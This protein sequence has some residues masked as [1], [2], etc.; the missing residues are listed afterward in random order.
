MQ[1]AFDGLIYSIYSPSDFPDD[2]GK[3]FALRLPAGKHRF[4]SWVVRG[5]F[6]T[7]A[8][9]EKPSPLEFEVKAGRTI[10]LGNLHLHLQAVWDGLGRQVAYD[11]S[12]EVRDQRDRDLEVYG[13]KYPQGKDAVDISLLAQGPWGAEA[14][15]S[16]PNLNSY[17]ATPRFSSGR[18]PITPR[19]GASSSRVFSRS[20]SQQGKA[21]VVGVLLEIALWELQ[22]RQ[23][24][25]SAESAPAAPS[26]PEPVPLAEISS[27]PPGGRES[28]C[29]GR[30]SLLSR[31]RIW[32][33]CQ[34]Q[35]W[36]DGKETR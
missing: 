20:A 18:Y 19:P 5:P 30:E 16:Y 14:A 8:P 23:R 9:K 26:D 2:A 13:L 29:A 11:A 7:M 1:V 4:D 17:Q 21:A 6:S 32:F 10:Y 24:S 22:R 25:D 12:A 36:G 15:V 27:A 33:L 3:L 35:I 28:R 34:S 31:Y